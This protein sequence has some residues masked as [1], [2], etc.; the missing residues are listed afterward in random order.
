MRAVLLAFVAFITLS[1]VAYVCAEERPFDVPKERWVSISPN[2]GIAIL[3]VETV[4][5]YDPDT[6]K[7]RQEFL[8]EATGVLMA[9][10]E[11]KWTKIRFELGP[12]KLIPVK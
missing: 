4:T 10:V 3:H 12:A 1:N 5:I 7:S 11:G 6:R 8:G 2:V 9:K